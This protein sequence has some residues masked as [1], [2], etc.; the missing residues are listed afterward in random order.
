MRKILTA[1]FLLSACATAHVDER[2]AILQL[3]TQY[4]N[5]W[6]HLD[7]AF[8]ESTT[9][10]DARWINSSGVIANLQ[11][12]L[13]LYRSG[14]IVL[15]TSEETSL[16][17]RIYGDTAVVTGIWNISG[18]VGGQ[19]RSGRMRFTRVWVR[20]GRDWKMASWQGT[21]LPD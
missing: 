19:P 15:S 6:L 4:A 7:S 11:Q 21:N 20:E 5:A 10:A 2:N 9:E 8:I 3:E 1:V 13:A 16:E 12:S 14:R 18:T 17:V